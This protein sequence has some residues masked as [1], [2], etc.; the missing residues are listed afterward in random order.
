[1]VQSPD[2]H[3]GIVER[4]LL[5][6]PDEAACAAAAQ[7]LARALATLPSPLDAFISLQGGLGAGK[8]TVAR[9]LLR[10]L[11][12]RGRVKSP[13]F[14][15]MEPYDT[16][17]GP[18][19][20]FD[21]YRFEHLR[22]WEDAG[23]RDAFAAPGLKLTEWPERVQALLPQADLSLH[24]QADGEHAQGRAV[25]ALAHTGQGLALLKA[26]RP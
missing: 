4:R 10:A 9:H 22:E 17:L 7:A 3:S 26:L 14:A 1:L 18:A 23:F 13:T 11:G 19:L 6:W 2:V 24:L 8:T 15:V 5:H 21:F 16:P 12:V 20:H 25:H